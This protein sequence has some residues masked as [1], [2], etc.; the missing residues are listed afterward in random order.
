[1]YLGVRSLCTKNICNYIY[2][3]VFTLTIITITFTSGMDLLEVLDGAKCAS[4]FRVAI[5]RCAHYIAKSPN[6]YF[7]QYPKPYPNPNF[8]PNLKLCRNIV[9]LQYSAHTNFTHVRSSTAQPK[10]LKRSPAQNIST[11]TMPDSEVNIYTHNNMY[12]LYTSSCTIIQ[13]LR[14]LLTKPQF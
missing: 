1:M 11:Q 8:Y 2:A 12:N 10:S 4:P 14:A 5:S 9:L 3:R 13:F 7:N 6:T